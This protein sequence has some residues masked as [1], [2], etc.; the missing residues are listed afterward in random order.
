MEPWTAPQA[1]LHTQK[2]SVPPVALISQSAHAQLSGDI[3]DSLCAD[4]F[5]ELSFD[6]R[7]AI[8]Q[9]DSG[10][11]KSDERQLSILGSRDPKPFPEISIEEAIQAWEQSIRNAEAISPLAMVLISRH[12]ELLATDDL[13]HREFTERESKRRKII[14]TSLS[15]SSED[16]IRWTGALGF[17]DLLS[18][19][20][21]C[22]SRVPAIFPLC[23]PADP[24]ADS[25]TKVVASWWQ[26]KVCFSSPVVKAGTHLSLQAILYRGRERETEPLLLEWTL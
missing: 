18:L 24:D 9:H 13:L 21:C 14:E 15:V 22:G 23:H 8:R 12:F 7:E 20:L 3:A 17:C 16:L 19:Y 6:V 10:W 4:L 25:A 26:T 1:F 5:G 2:Y 11:V